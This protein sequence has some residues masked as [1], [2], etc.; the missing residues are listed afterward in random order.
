MD[1][2]GKTNGLTI[3]DEETANR[4]AKAMIHAVELCGGGAKKDSP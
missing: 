3:R 2:T 4:V 1:A